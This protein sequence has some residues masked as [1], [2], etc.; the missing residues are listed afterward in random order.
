MKKSLVLV[1]A[2]AIALMAGVAVAG[3]VGP[4]PMSGIDGQNQCQSPA[5]Y[6][7]TPYPVWQR[8]LPGGVWVSP[9]VDADNNIYVTTNDGVQTYVALDTNGN[10]LW[11]IGASQSWGLDGQG[12]LGEVGGNVYWYVPVRYDDGTGKVWKLDVTNGSIVWQLDIPTEGGYLDLWGSR[13]KMDAAG[14]MYIGT[15]GTGYV[16]KIQDND[17]SGSIVWTRY[18][19][20]GG[21]AELAL[22]PAEDAVYESN[23]WDTVAGTD[24]QTLWKLSTTDGSVIW[25]VTFSD[26][27][28]PP[29]FTSVGGFPVLDDDGN[30]YLFF[31]GNT[32]GDGQF[33][34]GI[35]KFDPS[36]NVLW[37][38]EQVH[39]WYNTWDR[40]QNGMA[41][42]LDQTRI[43]NFAETWLFAFDTANGNILWT[44]QD[45]P[46]GNWNVG[47]GSY[48]FIGP[49]GKYYLGGLYW[50]SADVF[51]FSDNGTSASMDWRSLTGLQ[52]SYHGGLAQDG[53]SDLIVPSTDV[54]G[55]C[56]KL[57]NDGPPL[58]IV[59]PLEMGPLDEQLPIAGP[60]G[61]GYELYYKG[62]Q[63]P[64]TFSIFD[65]SLPSGVY[66]TSDGFVKG[67]PALGS[68]GTYNVTIQADDTVTTATKAYAIDV[69][70][71]P[72][73]IWGV[74]P[75]VLGKPFTGGIS[76]IGGTAPYTV[77]INKGS[78]PGTL[79]LNN[80]GTVT[81]TP[82]AAD[83]YPLEVTIT[84][85]AAESITVDVTVSVQDPRVWA[86]QQN[87]KRRSGLAL[88]SGPDEV[89]IVWSFQ[90][91]PTGP[92][93]LENGKLYILNKYRQSYLY[94]S[95][96]GGGYYCDPGINL[97]PGNWNTG[98][99]NPDIA[100]SRFTWACLTTDGQFQWVANFLGGLNPPNY[101][102]DQWTMGNIGVAGEGDAAD[103]CFYGLNKRI[104]AINK[105]D[106]TI[107]WSRE[108]NGVVEFWGGAPGLIGWSVN[109]FFTY[110]GDGTA[111][112][113]D[114]TLYNP[115]TGAIEWNSE[116]I[117]L[118]GDGGEGDH[119][120]D[121]AIYEL[122]D[123]GQV[124]AIQT[125]WGG[126]GDWPV[127][128]VA[129]RALWF[130]GGDQPKVLWS[131]G[132]PY[133]G[134]IHSG[135]TVDLANNVYYTY[136]WNG[137]Y[138]MVSIDGVTGAVRWA[139]PFAAGTE[140]QV[141]P[142][143]LSF[144]GKTLYVATQGRRGLEPGSSTNPALTFSWPLGNP[145]YLYAV[146]TVN[147]SIRWR[148]PLGAYCDDNP[149]YGSP[150]TCDIDGKVYFRTWGADYQ[151]WGRPGQDFGAGRTIPEDPAAPGT[152]GKWLSNP[153]IQPLRHW[154]VKDAGTEGQVVWQLDQDYRG[155]M[156]VSCRS[157]CFGPGGAL[158]LDVFMPLSA[159]S[160]NDNLEYGPASDGSDKRLYTA[161]EDDDGV[162]DFVPFTQQP[163]T[164][165]GSDAILYWWFSYHCLGIRKV[166]SPA[167][168][169]ITDVYWDQV[170]KNVV[171]KFT[172]REGDDY[173]LETAEGN[174]YD[175][176]LAWSTL[177]TVTA[178]AGET[179]VTDNLT[180]N[181][182]TNQFRFYRVK[183]AVET[184]YSA[185]TAGVF[186][187]SLTASPALKFISTPLVPDADHASVREI[188]GEGTARQIARTGFAVN[189]LTENT[190]LVTR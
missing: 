79:A 180:A 190:G 132:D 34:Q 107:A 62:A 186:E 1:I 64:V 105:A 161:D 6:E 76:I 95:A 16:Y 144:D 4:A 11:S 188:F 10:T 142:P 103:K 121:M 109:G 61:L 63:G 32:G 24:R 86:N 123:E 151:V 80:D 71:A 115:A 138:G 131:I 169:D 137:D 88:V 166:V 164:D 7:A 174:A 12:C 22:S 91:Q 184:Y 163:M 124:A 35:A 106:G 37:S 78:L 175:D 150:V 183:H 118:G 42:N 59:W 69:V 167:M 66:L 149:Y 39:G 30:I 40:G 56:S 85:F 104:A 70:V 143:A 17:T 47:S 172:G 187:L 93:L 5:T 48:P 179:T 134:V 126:G 52:S 114:W 84:D 157:G 38:T 111:W 116:T 67:T 119:R 90:N 128:G 87:T 89:N 92:E 189:D 122:A 27:T 146:N 68:A 145:S 133:P 49:T 185:Q 21:L 54:G 28:W 43:Y 171:V 83:D 98:S 125:G 178:A 168:P 29:E 96:I 23:V 82:T 141:S 117:W 147:G 112:P 14:D 159:L 15:D 55:G 173:D 160:R 9:L 50:A 18:T 127:E 19:D 74:N 120:G 110:S 165:A 148:L 108:A 20:H 25:K 135:V 94:S 75:G 97:N 60:N 182:L 31:E 140:I 176:G 77:T 44:A 13:M 81:G 158:Y 51:R 72:L 113:H 65:G 153:L 73:Q 33:W 152:A 2:L 100:Q 41:F 154:C 101:G 3:P 162:S 99:F 57:W 45:F 155:H 130:D 58:A 177:T 53:N 8:E 26:T 136:I 139:L 181:A 36:G 46:M 129:C 102:D 170:A 156:G